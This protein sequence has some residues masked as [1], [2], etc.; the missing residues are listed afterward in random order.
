MSESILGGVE[1]RSL[2][3]IANVLYPTIDHFLVVFVCHHDVIGQW[4]QSFLGRVVLEA[5]TLECVPLGW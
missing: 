5:N 2:I 4:L 3:A 1:E